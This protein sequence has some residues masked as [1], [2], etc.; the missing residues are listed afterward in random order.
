MRKGAGT[1]RTIF[2]ITIIA[3]LGGCATPQEMAAMDDAECR[4]WGV[5][6]GHPEYTKC[7]AYMSERRRMYAAQQSAALMAAGSAMMAAGQAT[8]AA[9]R[10]C[11]WAGNIWTCH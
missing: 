11:F 1:M 2:A 4:N 5:T 9:P 7:R 10:H 3:L 6:R 8:P